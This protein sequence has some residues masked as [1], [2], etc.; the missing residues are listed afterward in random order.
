MALQNKSEA[1]RT[2]QRPPTGVPFQTRARTIDHL[3]R[4]QIAD[5]PTAVS[6]LW[7]NSYDAY[8]RDVALHIF[9]GSPEIGLVTDDGSGMS[10]AGFRERWLVI[11]TES[12]IEFGEE[13]EPETFGL[14]ERVRQGEKGIG[15]LSAAFLAPISFVISKTTKDKFAAVLVDWRLFENPFLLIE[16]IRIPLVE[17]ERP[18][19]I[20]HL[21]KGMIDIIRSNFGVSKAEARRDPESR[22]ARLYDGWRRFSEYEEAQ[23]L[24]TTTHDEI[25]ASWSYGLAIEERHLAEWPVYSGLGAHGTALFMIGLHHD[26]AHWVRPGPKEDPANRTPLNCF[27]RR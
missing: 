11:G 21:T 24:N 1:R 6:E 20:H 17:F 10:L 2:A 4:G 14:D 5:A 23:K 8:A 3:G 27:G 26:L 9:D 18:E 7:K 12:K 22:V 15:R 16:D 13:E 25:E 19:D